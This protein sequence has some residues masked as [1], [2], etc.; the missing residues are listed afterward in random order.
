MAILTLVPLSE[1]TNFNRRPTDA[2]GKFRAIYWKIVNGAAIG[3]I[4]TMFEFGT[5]PPGA[6]RILPRLATMRC[7]AFGAARVM[8][9]GTRA[10]RSVD[11]PTADQAEDD[12]AFS[13]GLDLSAALAVV[14]NP[15]GT[16]VK[17]DLF[18]K[19]GVRVY[20]TVTGG[21]VPAAAEL[22]GYLPYLYE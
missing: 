6:V 21:T 9:I 2:H 1:A 12:D 20:G 7:T 17:F 18:S 16:V 15:F 22:E 8:K 11:G 10:Y 14:P 5:L 4:N 13:T 3:D 19:T